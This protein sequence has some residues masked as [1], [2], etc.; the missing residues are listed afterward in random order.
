MQT[1]PDFLLL[2]HGRRTDAD[3]HF[4][5]PQ[6]RRHRFDLTHDN[7]PR[8]SFASNG[9]HN[10]L[11]NNPAMVISLGFLTTNFRYLTP[12]VCLLLFLF[13]FSFGRSEEPT[14]ELQSLMRQS[15]AVF[16]STN[17]KTNVRNDRT[18]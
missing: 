2:V 12:P 18:T 5:I 9:L 8:P 13:R 17:N 15:Y 14:S 3:S 11:M 10:G 4:R 6:R 1:F 16:C 7:T